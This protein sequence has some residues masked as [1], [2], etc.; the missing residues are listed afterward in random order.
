MRVIAL[1]QHQGAALSECLLFASTRGRWL[2]STNDKLFASAGVLVCWQELID[3]I[4]KQDD[5][6][7]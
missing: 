5:L 7:I 6:A 2:S 1:T 3:V 4:R